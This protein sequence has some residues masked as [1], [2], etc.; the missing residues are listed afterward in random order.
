MKNTVYPEEA[1]IAVTLN[2]N[3][4]CVMCNIWKNKITNEVPP[5]F[6]KKLP[7][8]LKEINITGGEPFLRNDLPDIVNIMRKTSVHARLLINTNGYLVNQIKRLMQEI[9]R[10]DPQIALRVSLDGFGHTHTVIRGL[11]NFFENAIKT[12]NYLKT[13]GVKDLGVSYTLM[14]QNKNDLL[15]LFNYCHTNNLEFSLTVS[16]DSPIYFGV[17]KAKLRPKVTKELKQIFSTLADV[18]Y[19]SNNPKEWVR[20]WF[21]EG[22]LSYMNTNVRPLTC[23]ATKKFFYLDSVGRVYACH[24]KSWLIGDLNKHTFKQI[25]EGEMAKRFREKAH[26]CNDCWMVCSARS[27]IKSNILKVIQTIGIRKLRAH[28]MT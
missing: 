24:L 14:E 6:Y 13:V 3:A 21:D 26:N 20:A 28:I 25:M 18:Q 11:P 4:R 2:C 10:Y 17:G 1:I 12:L 15:P 9:L 5:S 19:R 16:T 7:S 23:Q 27:S 22:L 8:T